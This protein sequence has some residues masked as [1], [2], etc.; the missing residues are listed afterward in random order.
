MSSVLQ[1]LVFDLGHVLV[2]FDWEEICNGFALVSQKSLKE[3]RKTFH[4]CSNLGYE[5]GK[6]DTDGFLAELNKKLG[7]NL[8]LPEFKQ[9]WVAT[10]CENEQMAELLS[11]LKEQRP[12]YLLSNTNELHFNHLQEQFD[13]SR[14]FQELILS[15]EVGSVKPCTPIYQEVLRRSGL[16]A[17]NCLFVDDLEQNILAAQTLGLAT[18]HFSG[19][20]NLKNRLAALGFRVN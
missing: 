2:D 9:L 6:I 7:T 12:L 8:S 17:H 10:F 4:H 18:I 5:S 11:I 15:Y 1:L 20:D 16:P 19:V 14:H 3:L 13:I